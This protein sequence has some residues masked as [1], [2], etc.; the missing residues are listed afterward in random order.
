MS[1]LANTLTVGARSSPL[2]QAQVKEV[3]QELHRF[4]PLVVFQMIWMQTCGDKDKTTSLRLLEKTDFFT[5][6]IDL[7][8]LQGK[9]RVTIHSAKDLPDPLAEGLELIALTRGVDPADSLVFREGENL[10]TLAPNSLVGTSSTRREAAIASLR[11]DLQCLCIRGTIQERLDLL[12]QR[13]IDALIVAEAALIRLQLT[14]L[15]RMRLPFPAAQYQGQLAIVAR[16]GDEEM[17]ELFAPL[18]ARVS[19]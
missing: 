8:Q 9:V 19:V 2:S 17:K 16:V 5:K 12:A 7:A 3:L 14:H 13:K 4:H 11:A 18:D 10:Q 6:E 1:S 15:C